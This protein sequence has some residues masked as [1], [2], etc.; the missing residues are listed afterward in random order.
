MAEFFQNDDG[1][2]YHGDVGPLKRDSDGTLRHPTSNRVLGKY[3]SITGSVTPESLM[4]RPMRVKN[5]PFDAFRGTEG[6]PLVGLGRQIIQFSIGA[7]GALVAMPFGGGG[8]DTLVLMFIGFVI[9][10]IVGLFVAKR[11]LR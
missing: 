9:G 8:S 10:A 6:R 2:F 3:D 7:L 11:L 4:P 5:A 1:D